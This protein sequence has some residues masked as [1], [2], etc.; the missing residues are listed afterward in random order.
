MD[1]LSL[2]LDALSAG[3]TAAVRLGTVTRPG[4]SRCDS[5]APSGCAGTVGGLD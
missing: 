2:I 1:L 5:S 3:A 4:Q